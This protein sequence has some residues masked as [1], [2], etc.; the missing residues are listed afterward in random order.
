MLPSLY[1]MLEKSDL[2]KSIER[3]IHGDIACLHNKAGY[4]T[5]QST[6]LLYLDWRERRKQN[7]LEDCCWRDTSELGG[8][9]FTIG[10][11][12]L[13]WGTGS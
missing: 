9:Y 12:R 10:C 1:D 3:K 6:L 7:C 4:L 8:Y 5:L 13:Y 2:N 11:L